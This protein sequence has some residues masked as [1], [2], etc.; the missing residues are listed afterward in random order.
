MYSARRWFLPVPSRTI[1]PWL[2]SS[3]GTTGAEGEDGAERISEK[4][5]LRQHD[6]PPRY[7][8]V[9]DRAGRHRSHHGGNGLSLRSRRLGCGKKSGAAR[10][11]RIR[12]AADPRRQRQTTLKNLSHALATGGSN[13]SSRSIA[14]LGSSPYLCPP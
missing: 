12:Q 6:L 9:S 14:S 10:Y 8:Q 13:R 3:R 4:Y 5:L 2:G 11:F 1:R 7:D